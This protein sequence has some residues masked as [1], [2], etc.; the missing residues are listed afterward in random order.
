MPDLGDTIEEAA[1][2]VAAA[3]GDAGSFTERPLADLIEADKHLAAKRG[4]TKRGRGLRFSKVI[5]GGQIDGLE[6]S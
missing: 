1:G 3:S 4:S 2:N 6:T 5:F